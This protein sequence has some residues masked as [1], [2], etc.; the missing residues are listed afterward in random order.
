MDAPW[1]SHEHG[2]SWALVAP[3]FAPA[4]SYNHLQFHYGHLPGEENT[5]TDICSCSFDLSDTELTDL[6]H[7]FSLQ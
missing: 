2:P 4:A 1:G 5:V 3:P 6:L 7:H